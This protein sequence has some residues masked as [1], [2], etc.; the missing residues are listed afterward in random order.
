MASI[1][2]A[3]QTPHIKV[4]AQHVPQA[5]QKESPQS[6][7][8]MESDMVQVQA[9][10]GM[11]QSI[12]GF[13]AGGAPSAV[14]GAGVGAGLFK[15]IGGPVKMGAALGAFTGSLTGGVAGAMSAN[16]TPEEA[17]KNIPSIAKWSLGVGAA[18]AF[19]VGMT[20][21][22]PTAPVGMAMGQLVAE[23]E[24]VK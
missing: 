4:K 15:L 16:M 21:A 3:A 8:Q 6:S 9:K 22:L 7:S 24:A 18:S 2:P 19:V 20:V 1:Q 11:A 5:V 13:V 14:I 17:Q 23:T 10:K 12:K